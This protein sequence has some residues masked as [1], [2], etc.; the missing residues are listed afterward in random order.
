MCPEDHVKHLHVQTRSCGGVATVTRRYPV[1]QPGTSTHIFASSIQT[2]V[3]FLA[4]GNTLFCGRSWCEAS[5]PPG[6]E[7]H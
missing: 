3:A 6:V 1:A 7:V 5:M 2:T 4:V